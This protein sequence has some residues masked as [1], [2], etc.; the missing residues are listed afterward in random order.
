M[1]GLVFLVQ[2]ND[3]EKLRDVL[4]GGPVTPHSYCSFPNCKRCKKDVV[5]K[6]V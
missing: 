2:L 5:N 6:H 1:N 3:I 4:K